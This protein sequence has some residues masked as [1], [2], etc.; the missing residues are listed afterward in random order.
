[1]QKA[2]L[3]KNQSVEEIVFQGNMTTKIN[4]YLVVDVVFCFFRVR[5]CV[6]ACV[7]ATAACEATICSITSMFKQE[8]FS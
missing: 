2:D 3:N 8:S 7:R 4:S 6:R 1:M 5:V